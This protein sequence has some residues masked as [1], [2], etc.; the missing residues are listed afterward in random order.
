MRVNIV[1]EKIK[2]NSLATV[3]FFKFVMEQEFFKEIDSNKSLIIWMDCGPHFR[4][5]ACMHFFLKDLTEIGY[6]T[7]VN[8][9]GEKHGKSNCDQHFSTITSYLKSASCYKKIDSV[10]DIVDAVDRHQNLSNINRK[11]EGLCPINVYNLIY[12]KRNFSSTLNKM[13]ITDLTNYYNFY[14]DVPGKI[15]TK[16][17]TNASQIKKIDEIRYL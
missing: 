7:E 14:S 4:S 10:Q 8:F 13:I 17:L 5:A 16:V 6:K 1:S 9:F 3:L 15:F 2:N 11:N 12:N